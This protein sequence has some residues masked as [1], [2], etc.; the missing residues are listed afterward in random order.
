MSQ[1]VVSFVLRFVREAGEDEQ[2]RWR[3][4]IKHVQ[5]DSETHFTQFAEAL[6]FMQS[7]VNETIRASFA[8]TKKMNDE[9]LLLE[10]A[11]LWGEFMPRYTRMM[12]DSMG[13]MMGNNP[14]MA[15]QMEKTI[16]AAMSLWGLPVKQPAEQGNAAAN[17][18]SLTNQ[19]ASLTAKLDAL[20][21][22]MADLK[23]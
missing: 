11:R 14:A 6:E 17:L 9:N 8:G 23:K 20:E 16:A 2:A 5:S 3:G 10:T 21:T 4:I 18:D 12:M 22:K 19:V 7:Q 13:E 1:E 15:Q